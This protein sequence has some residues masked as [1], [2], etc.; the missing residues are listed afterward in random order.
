MDKK[1]KR[2][3]YYLKC[4]KKLT[5]VTN[6]KIFSMSHPSGNYNKNTIKIGKN[7]LDLISKS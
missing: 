5:S 6:K 4:K 3:N 1:N 2:I 7:I